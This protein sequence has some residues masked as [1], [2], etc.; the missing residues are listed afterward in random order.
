MRRLE[1]R[2][3]PLEVTGVV[4]ETD[5]LVDQCPTKPRLIA[6]LIGE[7]FGFGRA[8]QDAL[9]VPERMERLPHVEPEVDPFQHGLSTRWEV[10][11]GDERP[12]EVGGCLV[13]G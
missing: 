2:H 8:L 6:Q 5:S 11:E 9:A 4:V 10:C 13:I 3:G 7:R 12:L 1:P